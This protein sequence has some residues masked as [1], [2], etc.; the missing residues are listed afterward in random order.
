VVD[1]DVVTAKIATIDR[2]LRRIEDTRGARR[3][4]LLPIEVEDVVV[5]VANKLG[6]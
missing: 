3:Q 4:V 1:P 2:C 6:L 5:L